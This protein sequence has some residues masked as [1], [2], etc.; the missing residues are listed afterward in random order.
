M[1][2]SVALSDKNGL[3][4]ITVPPYFNI[5]VSSLHPELLGLDVPQTPTLLR[6]LD[7]VLNDAALGVRVTL[8]KI[9]TEG[10][11]L[12]VLRG[13]SQLLSRRGALRL[14]VI[15]PEWYSV[16]DLISLMESYGFHGTYFDGDNGAT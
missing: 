16:P 5:G 12:S 9:D 15:I 7:D 13:M 3:A 6:R 11:E 1:L 14:L 10:H 2:V 4:R 8:V